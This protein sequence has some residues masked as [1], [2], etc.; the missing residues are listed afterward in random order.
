AA[1]ARPAAPAPRA[2]PVRRS[3]F[4]P[5]FEASA[6]RRILIGLV[7]VKIVGIV[8]VFTWSGQFGF[9]IVK[10][11]WSRAVE[12]PT[13]AALLLTLYRYGPAVIPR[14][15][16]HFLVVGFLVANVLSVIFAENQYI[17]IFGERN[18]YIGLTN[19]LH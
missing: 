13:A 2:G 17:S 5:R 8:V 11:F 1:S 10:A 9:D 15:R 7:L 4:G 16:L 14:T 3:A 12:W 19:T 6:L 18:R